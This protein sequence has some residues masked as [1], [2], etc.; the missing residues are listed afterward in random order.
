MHTLDDLG[1]AGLYDEFYINSW[2]N[3][4]MHHLASRASVEQ[5]TG[6]ALIIQDS[7]KLNYGAIP[8]GG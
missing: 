3:N 7:G 6:Y 5:T 2:F 8:P 4:Y 1:Y